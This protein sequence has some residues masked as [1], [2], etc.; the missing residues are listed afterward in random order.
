MRFLPIITKPRNAPTYAKPQRVQG[1]S[2]K[3][4]VS[5]GRALQEVL[6]RKLL[7][8]RSLVRSFSRKKKT[9]RKK[10]RRRKKKKTPRFPFISFVLSSTHR[11]HVESNAYWRL[12]LFFNYI[13][14]KFTL[15]HCL[16]IF[17]CFSVSRIH[18]LVIGEANSKSSLASQPRKAEIRRR[19]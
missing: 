6:Q 1:N 12:Q 19:S 8:K 17:R 3:K 10:T 7:Y 9:K 15:T 2:M 11:R 13:N 18:L 14:F 5:V 4:Q 16:A